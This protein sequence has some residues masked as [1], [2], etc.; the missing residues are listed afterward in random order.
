MNGSDIFGS[1]KGWQ[2]YTARAEALVEAHEPSKVALLEAE[3]G[4]D[5]PTAAAHI[6]EST[7]WGVETFPQFQGAKGDVS[8]RLQG[9]RARWADWKQAE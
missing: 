5:Q 8:E 4:F 7:D 9:L 6:L 1:V 3:F 2:L